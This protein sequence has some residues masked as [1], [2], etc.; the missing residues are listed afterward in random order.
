MKWADSF[1]TGAVAECIKA[2]AFEQLG[3]AIGR[4]RVRYP[5][6]S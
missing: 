4:F 1:F 6:D 5:A 3:L 2:V